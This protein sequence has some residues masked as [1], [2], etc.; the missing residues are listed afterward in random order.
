MMVVAVG[1]SGELKTTAALREFQLLKQAHAT[2]QPEGSVH[3]GE[4]Y[5]LLGTQ[6]PLMHLLST[7]VTAFP[8]ALKQGQNPLALGG[9][10]LTAIVKAGPQ[11]MAARGGWQTS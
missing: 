9:Q 6:K 3:G 8:N 7:K 4:G 11:P 2:E 10:A 5:P 1:I